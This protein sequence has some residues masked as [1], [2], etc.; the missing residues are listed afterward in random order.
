MSDGSVS[1]S[2]GVGACWGGCNWA[3]EEVKDDSL[4]VFISVF[5]LAAVSNNLNA[6]G[7]RP[8]V[9]ILAPACFGFSPC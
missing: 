3:V 5:I 7:D 6:A 8:L 4:A 2:N 1:R 9:K